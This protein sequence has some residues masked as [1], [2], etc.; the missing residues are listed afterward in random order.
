MSILASTV[1]A[2][3]CHHYVVIQETYLPNCPFLLEL[4]HG[5]SF[6]RLGQQL[7]AS[8]YR[9]L[10]SILSLPLPERYYNVR[11]RPSSREENTV[12]R[13]YVTCSRPCNLNATV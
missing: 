6:P 2:G 3:E 13:R 1:K 5:L 11:K 7:F 12:I 9:P 8:L 4:G 10:P